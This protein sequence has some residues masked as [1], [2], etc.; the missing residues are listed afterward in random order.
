MISNPTIGKKK[1][2]EGSFLPVLK[3][4]GGS[5]HGHDCRMM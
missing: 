5:T 1:A 4:P 2:F 3:S